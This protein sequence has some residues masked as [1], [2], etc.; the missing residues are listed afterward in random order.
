MSYSHERFVISP[1]ELSSAALLQHHPDQKMKVVSF[2][3]PS[4]K[5]CMCEAI[6]KQSIKQSVAEK[7]VQAAFFVVYYLL[8]E[9]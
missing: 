9:P 4:M 2:Q 6:H 8:F 3:S 5:Q 1:A 7:S